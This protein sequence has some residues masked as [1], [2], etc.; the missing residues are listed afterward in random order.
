M[1]L[2]RS[3][4]A[5]S[6]TSLTT[7]SKSPG[8]ARRRTNG[9]LPT[10]TYSPVSGAH[11]T[12]PGS[13]RAESLPGESNG[14]SQLESFFLRLASVHNLT[15]YLTS[16][17]VIT[18]LTPEQLPRRGDGGTAS[19]LGP[20]AV[21]YQPTPTAYWVRPVRLGAGVVMLVSILV[22]GTRMQLGHRTSPFSS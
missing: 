7:L 3:Q 21:H 8:T 22:R 16:I 6:R 4:S 15:S 12:S 11:G 1:S 5:A 2:L 19:D 17:F 13:G 14:L 18:R 20:P 9:Y 10:D